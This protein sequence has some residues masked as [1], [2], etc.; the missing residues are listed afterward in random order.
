MISRLIA[1]GA[2]LTIKNKEGQSAREV[3]VAAA[4]KEVDGT[5]SWDHTAEQKAGAAE[6]AALLA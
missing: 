6:C 5:N 4:A 3:I 2:N 1:A